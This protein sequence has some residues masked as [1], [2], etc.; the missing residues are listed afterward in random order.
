MTP[1]SE[2]IPG[3]FKGGKAPWELDEILGVPGDVFR[4]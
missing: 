4:K 2:R 3:G 1:K